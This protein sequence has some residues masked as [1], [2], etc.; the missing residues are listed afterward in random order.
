MKKILIIII[1]TVL[2]IGCGKVEEFENHNYPQKDVV[3]KVHIPDRIVTFS[4]AVIDFLHNYEL[5]PSIL[6]LNTTPDFLRKKSDGVFSA[7]PF[8]FS[9]KNKI[10]EMNPN[11]I[12]VSYRYKNMI[13]EI[14]GLGRIVELNTLTRDYFSGMKY[15][16]L[17]L[18][19]I[20]DKVK[21]VNYDL[22]KVEEERKLLFEK[23]EKHNFYLDLDDYFKRIGKKASSPDYSEED[24][25]SNEDIKKLAGD[26]KIITVEEDETDV[27]GSLASYSK[28]IDKLLIAIDKEINDG[29]RKDINN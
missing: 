27:Y 21:E 22:L 24:N 20:F 2:F 25:E 29:K 18:A 6:T 1:C 3:E 28:R 4:P 11:Y 17:T 23:A 7:E 13:D 14:K 9:D 19:K 12:F 16:Y 10:K 5:H 15:N 8:Y 26:K